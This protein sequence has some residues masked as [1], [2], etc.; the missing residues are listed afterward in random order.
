M[1]VTAYFLKAFDRTLQSVSL[2]DGKAQIETIIRLIGCK[3][4]D[5]A[6]VD[7]HFV[8][9]ERGLADGMPCVTVI[10]GYLEPIAGNLIITGT[11][12]DEEIINPSAPIQAFAERIT[13]VHPV[14]D[15]VF[16]TGSGSRRC[17]FH[18]RMHDCRPTVIAKLN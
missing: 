17:R 10:D 1:S 15:P 8:F 13:L 7:G 2:P 6:K 16:L 11:D 12:E 9:C 18:L 5:I 3:Q 4:L 14:I